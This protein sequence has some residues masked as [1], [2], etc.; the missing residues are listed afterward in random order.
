MSKRFISRSA[1]ALS[2]VAVLALSSACSSKVEGSQA[3]VAGEVKTG[4]GVADGVIKLG[5]ITDQS[6][7]FAALGK[8]ITQ[9]MQLFWEQH[10]AAGG[11]C[12]QYAVEL[13]VEDAQY[14]V[15]L[16]VQSYTNLRTQVLAMQQS[17][18]SAATLALQERFAEDDMLAV[19]HTNGPELLGDERIVM[20]GATFDVEVINGLSALL[21]QGKI[22]KGDALGHIYFTGGYGEGALAGAEAFAAEHGMTVVKQQIEPTVRDLGATVLPLKNAGVSAIVLSAAPPQLA[23]LMLSSG[24]QGLE[25]PVLG[26]SPAFAA[27]LLA[28]PAGPALRERYFTTYP[29]ASF[30]NKVAGEFRTAYVKRF[31]EP[32]PTLQI[33]NGYAEGEAMRQILER[34][35]KDGEL[36][37]EGVLAAKK[38]VTGVSTGG[39]APDLDLSD[40]SRAATKENY[41]LRAADVPGGLTL[42]KGPFV[43]AQAKAFA[44]K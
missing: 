22:K 33:V 35:C 1:L 34:A 9:S 36:T 25:V 10:N 23:S 37:P 7:V 41:L 11:I 12:D 21:E 15:P 6:G 28:S 30:D 26:S 29:V 24:T 44:G 39:L 38:S 13:V 18:G 19:A 14:K 31:G 5:V 8:E 3:P 43:S 42:V 32:D 4:R 20:T 17:L 27:G 40:P 2:A 16:A